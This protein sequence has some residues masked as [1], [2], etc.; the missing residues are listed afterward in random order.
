MLAQSFSACLGDETVLLGGSS[1]DT[2]CAYE[3]HINNQRQ[4]SFHWHDSG[5]AEYCC[6][7]F[8]DH[9]FERLTRRFEGN[10]RTRPSGSPLLIFVREV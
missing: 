8:S 9:V 2:D 10:R 3:L 5:Q 4:P 6:S 1:A 7:P